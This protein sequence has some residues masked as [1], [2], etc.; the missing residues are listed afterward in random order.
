EQ[1]ADSDTIYG[2][3]TSAYVAAFVGQQNF[4]DGTV[5]D[6]VRGVATAEALLRPAS[7]IS[8]LRPGTAARA[9]VRPEF[10]ELSVERPAGDA[11]LVEGRVIGQSHLGELM[12][13][14]VQL[15]G[16]APGESGPEAQSV[17]SR[18]PTPDSPRPPYPARTLPGRGGDGVGALASAARQGLPRR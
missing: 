2:S 5:T 11:N 1:L 4:F 7:A 3:P 17:L 14:L 15:G 9:A 13:F 18:R 12:Q 6:D 8:G 10:V 16:A